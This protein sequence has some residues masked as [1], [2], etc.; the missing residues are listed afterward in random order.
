M[1]AEYRSE[2]SWLARE[3]GERMTETLQ[4]TQEILKMRHLTLTLTWK[5]PRNKTKVYQ[6]LK[7]TNLMAFSS[8]V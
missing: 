4:T 7:K 8:S 1:A 2:A 5:L 3:K 6:S